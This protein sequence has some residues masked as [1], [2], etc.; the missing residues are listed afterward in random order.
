MLL[1]LALLLSEPILKGFGRTG[2]T[3]KIHLV[4]PNAFVIDN[5]RFE[6]EEARQNGEPVYWLTSSPQIAKALTPPT[7]SASWNAVLVQ[8]AINQ[9]VRASESLHLYLKNER[10]P[11]PLPFIQTPADFHLHAVT[12]TLKRPPRAY[13][14]VS[15]QQKLFI[16]AEN[17]LRVGDADAGVPFAPPPVGQGTL[18]ARLDLKNPLERKTSE[19]ALQAFAEVYGLELNLEDKVPQPTPEVVI[20]DRI[21][22]APQPATWYLVTNQAGLS[23]YPNVVYFPEKLL[24]QASALVASGHLPEWLGQRLLE[25]WDLQGD[26]TPMSSRELTRLFQPT[27][28]PAR[29]P[30][31]ATQQILFVLLLVLIIFER[32]IALTRNA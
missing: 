23:T 7:G 2:F 9:V 29:N 17:H 25:H 27:A 8:N 20:T 21:P 4:H 12:D 16:D 15:N 31:M 22:T 1:V 5:Y 24:P 14:L 6:L 26:P 13:R 19:A 11:H 28:I 30:A 3:Q 10:L 18:N 32:I